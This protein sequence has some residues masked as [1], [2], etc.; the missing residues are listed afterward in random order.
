MTRSIIF[1]ILF[2]LLIYD[3]H[4]DE[5]I[6]TSDIWAPYTMDPV[7]G[8]DGYL[9]DLARAAFKLKGHQVIYKMR[10]YTRAIYE[11]ENGQSDGVVGIYRKDALKYGFIVPENE[12]GI[13]INTFF[14]RK[15]DSWRYDNNLKSESLKGKIIGVIKNYVFAEIEDYLQANQN[16]LSVQYVFGEAP[17]KTNLERLLSKRI[18]ITLDDKVVVLYTALEM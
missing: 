9:I 12:L 10:P 1:S 13:S 4:S 5:I 16:T 2:L 14:I 6:L 17:L 8:K 7:S 3:S 18:D 15:N 11:T